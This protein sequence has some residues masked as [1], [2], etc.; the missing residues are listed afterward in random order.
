MLQMLRVVT[1]HVRPGVG[2]G[3]GAANR[4]A[5]VAKMASHAIFQYNILSIDDTH[6]TLD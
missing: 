6:N 1:M 4:L 3:K 2:I 5:V